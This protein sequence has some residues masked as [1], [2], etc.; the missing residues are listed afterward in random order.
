MR[1]LI[2]AAT[3]AESALVIERLPHDRVYRGH[4]ISIL[5]TGVGLVA[6]AASTAAALSSNHYDFALNIGVCGSFDPAYPPGTVVRVGTERIA[7]LGAEDGEQFLS[8]EELGFTVGFS[9][10][11]TL[12]PHY[13]DNRALDALPGVRGIS[14]NT[15]HGHEPSI[16]ALRARLDP[17][18]ESMEGAAFV[19]AT[20]LHHIPAAQ[21]R[22]VSNMVERRNRGAWKLE[23]AIAT[24]TATTF[25]VLDAL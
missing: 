8:A 20:L 21:I 23:E 10:D 25:D 12:T 7:D 2:V 4:Q 6:T 22:A 13:W 5:A 15:A 11:G 18:V 9:V 17:Q 1:V 16:A 3:A 19:Y 14:A 24:V